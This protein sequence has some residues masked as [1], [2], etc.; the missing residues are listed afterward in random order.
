[1][2][3][4]GIHATHYKGG[5]IDRKAECDAYFMESLNAG[6]YRVEKSTM[7]G[8]VYY[9]AVTALKKYVAENTYEDLPEEKQFTFGVVFLTTVENSDYYNFCYKDL[10]E[11]CGSGYF[12]C[13]ES[14]LKLLSPTDNEYANNWRSRCREHQKR[15]KFLKNAPI[16]ISIEF[17]FNGKTC[18]VVKHKAAFQFRKPFWFNAAGNSFIRESIIP[19]DC[20]LIQEESE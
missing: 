2:G 5:T 12:D 20:R 4:T 1:M 11:D 18:R 13:H 3:W 8:S 9:A 19:D 7:V 14:I 6:H 16:G 10:D 17:E 15:R